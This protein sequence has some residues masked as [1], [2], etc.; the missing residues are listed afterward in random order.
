MGWVSDILLERSKH[1]ILPVRATQTHCILF[2]A[3]EA[4]SACEDKIDQQFISRNNRKWKI[5]GKHVDPSI[6]TCCLNWGPVEQRLMLKVLRRSIFQVCMSRF[7]QQW[8]LQGCC[9]KLLPCLKGPVP[10]NSRM[11]PPGAKAESVNASGNASGIKYL[12]GKSYF[13]EANCGHKR[14]E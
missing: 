3:K 11:D 10:G 4:Y 5:Q 6:S 2:I 14:V 12:R 7:W 8:V 1:K 13:A 9:Q